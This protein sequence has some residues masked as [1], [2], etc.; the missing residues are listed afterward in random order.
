MKNKKGLIVLSSVI[1]VCAAAL[2]ISPIIDWPIDTSKSGGNISKSSRFSRKTASEGLSNMEELILND[3]TYKNSIVTAYVVMQT[4]AQEF[5]ALV[6][7]SNEVA[8]EIP[9]FAEVLDDMNKV[10]VTV[11]N[12]CAS[13]VRAGENINATLNG[14]QR[15]DLAQNTINASLAY[16]TLQKQ[17]K[18]A[19]RFIDVTDKYLQT[20]EGTDR[21]KFVRDQWVDYQRMTAALDGDE[22]AAKALEEK[23]TLLSPEQTVA[24]LGS[25][26]TVHQLAILENATVAENFAVKNSVVGSLPTEVVAG[27]FKALQNAT[28]VSNSNS[29]ENSTSIAD[30]VVGNLASMGTVGNQMTVGNQATV[31]NQTTVGNQITVGNQATV[32][33]QITVGNQAT[34]GNQTVVGNQT[35]VASQIQL[36]NMNQIVGSYTTIGNSINAS[37]TNNISNSTAICNQVG[38][39]ISSTAVGA[40]ARATVF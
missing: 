26:T 14:E 15:P 20:A 28:I 31:G 6:D 23:G 30:H 8:G 39:I 2:V 37:V 32:G 24:S 36:G 33:N 3:P 27:V 4:R 12:V 5:S 21:L 17:N 10:Y 13:L 34:V 29:M 40:V 9:E 16:T 19:T 11:N 25:F 7:M 38:N 18:L 35:L 22:D 1:V